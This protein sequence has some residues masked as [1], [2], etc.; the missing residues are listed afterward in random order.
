[1]S[2]AVDTRVHVT[3]DHLKG[4]KSAARHL[5]FLPKQRALSVLNGRHQS[6]LRGRGLNFEEMRAYRRGDDIRSIDWKA[7]A[8]TG[9]AHVRVFSEERDRPALLVVDQRMSMF[10]GSVLN[11]KSVTAAEAASIAAH[12]ILAVGDRVG[13]IVFNEEN[14]SELT[15]KRSENTV[16]AFLNRISIYNKELSA[17]K[18]V[19]NA[20]NRFNRVLKSIS[21]VAHHDHM[22]IIFSDFAGVDDSTERYL[23]AIAQHN[24]LVLALVF[25]PVERAVTTGPK[26]VL[27][28]GVLQAEID[29]SDRYVTDSLTE[30]ARARLNRILSWQSQIRLSVLPLSSAQGTELQVLQ[31]LGHRAGRRG[32]KLGSAK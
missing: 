29:F 4:L 16:H 19:E 10:F 31:Q 8:R 20:P 21:K 11:M 15:P 2:A 6:R 3:L 1:M 13:G 28:D 18:P 9:S 7:T 26:A 25:D 27:S 32:S 30:L 22:V 24:D 5:S 23:S 14:L 17:R 12:R